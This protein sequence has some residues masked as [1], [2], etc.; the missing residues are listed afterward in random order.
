MNITSYFLK[1]ARKFPSKIA[2]AE[3]EKS[4]TFS[5]LEK[6]VIATAAY[7]SKMGIKKGD[8]VLVFVPM[9]IDLYRIVMALFYIGATAVFLD[10]WVSKKR[11]DICCEIAD[12]NGFIG[13]TKARILTLFSKQLRQIPIKLSLKKRSIEK[14]EMVETANE[15]TALITFTTGSTGTPKAAKRTHA[16]L[17]EQFE[18]LK[19]EIEPQPEDVDMPVLPILLFVNLG[20]GCTSVIAN[21]KMSKPDRI[22]VE[23]IQYQLKENKVNRITA[24]P[25][26]IKKL[27]EYAAQ[28]SF[29]YKKVD[30]VFTGGAPVF[31]IEASLYLKAF[32]ETT[33]KIVYGSTE[34]EPIS[35]IEAKDLANSEKQLS[36]G[37]AVGEV[38]EKTNLKIIQVSNKSIP[39]LS[40]TA[41]KELEVS[42]GEI[43]EIL[44]S[45]DH[46]LKEYF[47]NE[48]AFKQNK[49]VV[50]GVVWHRTGDSGLI[51]NNQLL[52]T[53]RCKQLIKREFAYIS[54]FI[55]ENHL[56]NTEGVRMGTI[57]ENDGEII[58]VTESKL[59]Q[60]WL[61]EK[62]D[63]ISFDRLVQVKSIPR[64][65]RHNSKID[66][67]KLKMI[68]QKKPIVI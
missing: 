35:S 51:E 41:L 49:I 58:I 57:L 17:N 6:E 10:E 19:A 32:P 50:D 25:F 20:I 61:Y 16:F 29:T 18:A 67:E 43:G 53:G 33:T 26:F 9:S 8:R 23:E 28:N 37:L 62:L 5:E 44:V 30:K 55:I 15:D 39:N 54:P 7:F 52:L 56:N 34:A 21:F 24:S 2:I 65:P 3:K 36:K 1:T 60:G 47:K 42:E 68:I 40:K 48:D 11:M 4:I 14:L 22:D 27:A 59:Q 66:Y 31:P 63:F 64:D 38:F 46:V 12:C 13:I 45:G